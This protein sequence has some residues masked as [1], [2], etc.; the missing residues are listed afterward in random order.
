MRNFLRK[1]ELTSVESTLLGNYRYRLT[2]RQDAMS[3]VS[4]AF[5]VLIFDVIHTLRANAGFSY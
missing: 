2:A 4:L 5:R 3:S 1:Y